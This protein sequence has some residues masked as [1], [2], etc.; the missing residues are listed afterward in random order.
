MKNNIRLAEQPDRA[1]REEVRCA[2]PGAD[3]MD[4][5]ACRRAVTTHL[6]SAAATVWFVASSIR[7]SDP[8][9]RTLS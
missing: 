4:G 5:A 1:H 9:V 6:T 8:V 2:R 3:E 7:I